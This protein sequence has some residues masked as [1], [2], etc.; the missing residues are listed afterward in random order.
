MVI[1]LSLSLLHASILFSI[2]FVAVLAVIAIYDVRQTKHSI[3]RN[4]PKVGHI[5]YILQF[6]R[7][8]NKQ[9]FI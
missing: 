7:N 6:L 2:G 8:E 3:L 9:Y 5:R 4:Y 1:L